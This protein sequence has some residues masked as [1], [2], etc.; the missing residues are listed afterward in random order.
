LND[1]DITASAG[2]EPETCCAALVIGRALKQY[3]E[4]PI[5]F[6]S[7]NIGTKHDAIAHGDFDPALDSGLVRLGGP[8]ET[9]GYKEA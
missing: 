8:G 9:R 5:N 3:G 7:I 2:L 6:R 4:P 1:D